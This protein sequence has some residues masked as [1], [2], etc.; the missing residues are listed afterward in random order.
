M[1]SNATSIKILAD[2][3][4]RNWQTD[5]KICKETESR[6]AKT[7]LKKKE[8]KVGDFTQYNFKT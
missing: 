2:I 1:D 4:F 3:Y 5:F 6:I 7:I 8:N